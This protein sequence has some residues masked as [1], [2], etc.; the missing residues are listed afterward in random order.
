MQPSH[1]DCLYWS[2]CPGECI[3]FILCCFFFPPMSLAFARASLDCCHGWGSEHPLSRDV[4]FSSPQDFP[5]PATC[6]RAR[7][8]R[9]SLPE[10]RLW[11]DDTIKP[12]LGHLIPDWKG[13]SHA[14][15]RHLAGSNRSKI[16]HWLALRVPCV[17]LSTGRKLA[18]TPTTSLKLGSYTSR[19]NRYT[20]VYLHLLQTE[21]G[22]WGYSQHKTYPCG[23]SERT[24]TRYSGCAEFSPACYLPFPISGNSANFL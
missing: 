7:R 1:T 23:D 19:F 11:C 17:L 10:C 6:P 22:L 16:F 4:G 24:G 18:W 5:I 21:L 8:Q 20:T 12:G 13:H 3:P 15:Q 9:W 2:C 14:T